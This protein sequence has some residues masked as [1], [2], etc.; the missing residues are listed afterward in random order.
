MV[1]LDIRE[2]IYDAFGQV[3]D[4]EGALDLLD[5]PAPRRTGKFV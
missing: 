3:G 1:L 5:R 4:F 2:L